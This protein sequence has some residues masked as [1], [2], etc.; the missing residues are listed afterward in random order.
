MK[1]V[2]HYDLAIEPVQK[3]TIEFNSEVL[4]LEMIGGKPR[5]VVLV[6]GS[7]REIER[8]FHII[9]SG[10]EI[11]QRFNRTNYCGSFEVKAQVGA[12]LLHVFEDK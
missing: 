9:A 10:K 2:R 1:T 12:Q 6:D 8:T 3:I 7:F 5:L 4:K 11:P